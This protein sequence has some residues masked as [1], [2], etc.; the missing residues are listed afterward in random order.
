MQG[1]CAG[2]TSLHFALTLY[3]SSPP[4]FSL[5]LLS[6]ISSSFRPLP[7]THFG[8]IQFDEVAQAIG[9]LDLHRQLGIAQGLEHALQ[10]GCHVVRV[11]KVHLKQG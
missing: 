5:F 4:F 10:Q 3:P 11:S 2:A 8:S 9:R 7:P 1:K 6:S